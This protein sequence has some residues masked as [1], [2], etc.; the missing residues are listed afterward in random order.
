MLKPKD[1]NGHK[2]GLI[3]S[4]HSENTP[5]DDN[6]K[7]TSSP[8]SIIEKQNEHSSD[9]TLDS[10]ANEE[11]SDDL[12]EL[13]VDEQIYQDSDESKLEFISQW[14]LSNLT[15]D[16]LLK[17]DVID[18]QFLSAYDWLLNPTTTDDNEIPQPPTPS[19]ASFFYIVV[20]VSQSPCPSTRNPTRSDA[21]LVKLFRSINK[22]QVDSNTQEQ[23]INQY[24][25]EK[26][27]P[28]DKYYMPN[29][30][31]SDLESCLVAHDLTKPMIDEST[32]RQGTH[33]LNS[34]IHRDKEKEIQT[35]HPI[36]NFIVKLE[37]TPSELL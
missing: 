4:L 14:K 28:S 10:Y 24:V 17:P 12:D 16:N 35:L 22:Q 31:L 18:Q 8:A 15:F 9:K 19:F 21:D 1:T 30:V 32:V 23:E 26:M 37:H 6:L 2:D 3:I 7:M 27:N 20:A 36:P 34:I 5:V 11:S 13:N 25:Q 29:I 33:I